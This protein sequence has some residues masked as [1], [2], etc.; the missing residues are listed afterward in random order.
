MN[1]IK[2]LLL[3][4]KGTL[5]KHQNSS[6]SKEVDYNIFKVLRL[7]RNE[8]K[9]HSRLIADLMNPRGE[10][11][12]WKIFLDEFIKIIE[13]KINKKIEL[14]TDNLSVKTEKAIGQI[15]DNYCKGGRIDIY[16]TDQTNQI[17]IETKIDAGDQ[18]HQLFRYH[19]FLT[20]NKKVDGDYHLIYLTL[21][22]HKPSIPSTECEGINIANEII[23]FS[24][25]VDIFNWL[26]NSLSKIE[27]GTY[28]KSSITQYLILI[29][30]LRM[31]NKVINELKSNLT[32]SKIINKHYEEARIKAIKKFYSVLAE[33]DV[34]E[35][36]EL[37]FNVSRKNQFRKT[38]SLFRE[39][40]SHGDSF[41]IEMADIREDFYFGIWT[42]NT[43]KY[44]KIIEKI[45]DKKYIE[46]TNCGEMKFLKKFHT[47]TLLPEYNDYAGL[48]LIQD[49]H[50]GKINKNFM[51]KLIKIFDQEFELINGNS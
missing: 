26:E 50:R 39:F 10:N 1:D 42:Q 29:E 33:A 20:D 21:N 44:A 51:K 40:N 46:K 6:Y 8:E 35:K 12:H 34:T 31:K 38:Y 5:D 23:Q 24:F 37:K 18:K 49:Y 4:I 14:K 47:N 9:L 15:S 3:N 11:K 28:L 32:T 48:E 43:E 13:S 16:L 27:S 30:K 2:T 41:I 22:G 25:S 7:E 17:A 45:G 19:N 36:K